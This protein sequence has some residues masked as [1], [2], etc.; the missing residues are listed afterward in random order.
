MFKKILIANRGRNRLPHHQDG[1]QDGHPTVAI[2]RPT[3]TRATSGLADEA[4][5]RRGAEPR[6]VPAG[7]Q[8]HPPP[9]APGAQAVHPGY[10]FLSENEAFARRRREE[11]IV[12]IG[13]KHYSIAA[14]GDKIASKKLAMRPA[15]TPSG[16]ERGHR[17]ARARG[18][19]RA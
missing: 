17:D 15:S 8:D 14:M 18:R 19:D 16:L 4:V 1:A 2:P 13:P 9:E 7:R 10:G 6:V 3:A 11:G 12:F 5:H